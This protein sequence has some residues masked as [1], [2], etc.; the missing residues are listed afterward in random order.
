MDTLRETEL[1][2]KMWKS[3]H[4][5]WC[6]WKEEESGENMEALDPA[7]T[8]TAGSSNASYR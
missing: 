4:A 5:P 1:L 3:G 2:N 7:R 6:T 8:M